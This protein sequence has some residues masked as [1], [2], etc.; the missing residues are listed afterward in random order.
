MVALGFNPFNLLGNA[1]SNLSNAP[2]SAPA[3][4]TTPSASTPVSPNTI[5]TELKNLAGITTLAYPSDV[6]KYYFNILVSEYS[7]AGFLQ[8]GKLNPIA[9]YVLPLPMPL[10]DAHHIA[11][12]ETPIGA[13]TANALK[14][15]GAVLDTFRNILNMD[16][17]S[18]M[19][20]VKA[21]RDNV[22]G[23]GAGI[24][25]RLDPT[26]VF[27]A[28]KAFGGFSPNQFFTILLKGPKYKTFEFSWRVS[29]KTPEESKTLE[30]ML[31]ELNNHIAPGLSEGGSFFKFPKVF[32]LA[33]A[34]NPQYMF[35]FK[36]AVCES[37]VV[38]RSPSGQPAF[39]TKS[40]KTDG[41]N[42]PEGYDFALRFLELELWLQGDWKASNLPFDTQGA[43][44]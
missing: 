18:V 21:A 30:K 5:A 13:V 6:P 4:V 43:A 32:Q 20:T 27:D 44:R 38:N 40:D 26:G 31:R 39:Y 19:K 34:P 12:E 2:S 7:R 35:R 41:L 16:S 8:L 25:E 1:D 9:N 23:A 15:N 33:F 11:Y 29:P 10:I 24:V 17:A 36:P 3:P 37:L 28:A 42:A 14:F 22:L